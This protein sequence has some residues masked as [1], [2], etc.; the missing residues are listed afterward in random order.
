MHNVISF[1]PSVKPTLFE[2][3][4]QRREHFEETGLH[5]LLQAGDSGLKGIVAG[6]QIKSQLAMHLHQLPPIHWK[7]A[8]G[9]RID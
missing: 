7:P 1:I 8:V 6:L 9:G 5:S 2:I 3:S 4:R